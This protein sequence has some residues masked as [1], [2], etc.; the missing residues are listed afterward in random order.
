MSATLS[1]L[2]SNLDSHLAIQLQEQI[3]SDMGVVLDDKILELARLIEQ[4][5]SEQD[6]SKPAPVAGKNPF[7]KKK[8]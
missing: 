5:S 2:T 1:K 6:S 4:A 7:N 3:A 8:G